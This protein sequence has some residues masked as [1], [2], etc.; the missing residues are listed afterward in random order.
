MAHVRDF[1]KLPLHVQFWLS[2]LVQCLLPFHIKWWAYLYFLLTLLLM[3]KLTVVCVMWEEAKNRLVWGSG[4]R[5]V[6]SDTFFKQQGPSILAD[7]SFLQ[8]VC[9][10]FFGHYVVPLH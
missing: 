10:V 5:S 8:D 7:F 3:V 6:F 4:C 9:Q 2:C 1:L